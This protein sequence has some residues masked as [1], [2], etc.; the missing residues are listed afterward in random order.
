MEV[1]VPHAKVG[2]G[3]RCTRPLGGGVLLPADDIMQVDPQAD[4]F[5]E[6]LLKARSCVRHMCWFG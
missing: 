2:S 5:W 6:N 3:R 1:T 4:L